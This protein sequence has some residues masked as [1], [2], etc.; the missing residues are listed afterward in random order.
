MITKLIAVMGSAW[1]VVGGVHA[2]PIEYD[3]VIVGAGAAG[4]SAGF[5]LNESNQN[6]I[7]LEKNN[8]AGGIAENG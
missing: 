7:I 8:R 1:L 6:Y 5:T 2:T 3:Y 4:L